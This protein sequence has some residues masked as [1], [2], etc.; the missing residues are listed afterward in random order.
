MKKTFTLLIMC[1]L[2]FVGFSQDRI[3]A[4]KNVKPGFT[5]TGF[6]NFTGD[7]VYILDKDAR[8]HEN[9]EN[10]Y[11]AM[12]SLVVVFPFDAEGKFNF[13]LNVPIAEFNANSPDSK[14]SVRVFNSQTPFGVGMAVFPFKHASYFGFTAM[15]N[16]GRQNRLRPEVIRDQFFPIADYTNYNLHVAAPVPDEVLAPF[17]KK[18]TTLSAN[19]GLII[20]L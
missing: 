11:G 6:R 20:R 3:G 9:I 5:V 7:Y 10:Q 8:V 18:V 1:F 12:L 17:Y 14:E 15:L 13:L 2:S 19:A 4:F 16:V